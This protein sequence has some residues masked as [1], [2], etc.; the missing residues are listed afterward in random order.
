MKNKL[1]FALAGLVVLMGVL[2]KVSLT[3][4]YKE[5]QEKERLSAAFKA[6]SEVLKQI[7]ILDGRLAAQSRVLELKVDELCELYPNLQ[8]EILNLKI[9]PNRVEQL[10]QTSFHSEKQ[11]TT[12]IRDSVITD[13]IKARVFN[14]TD[15]YYTIRGIAIADTQQVN[16]QMCDTLVQV[17]Y[18]GKR[19]HPWLW[20][21]SKRQLEQ[22]V[23]LKNP[24]AKIEYSKVIRVVK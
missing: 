24:N 17:V 9:K 16:I 15:D 19:K 6:N 3:L 21:F 1:I 18:R 5:Q 7:E 20:F 2:L 8:Q 12:V 13:T 10:A 4:F 22:R 23:T 11:I 14:Y